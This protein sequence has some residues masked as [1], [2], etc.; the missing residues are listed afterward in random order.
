MN[1][2]LFILKLFFFVLLKRPT[3]VIR[4]S[5]GK[6]SL[7]SGHVSAHFIRDCQDV[8]QMEKIQSGIIFGVAGA[9]A[10]PV[11]KASKEVSP[12]GLQKIRNVWSFYS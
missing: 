2:S 3:F 10:K 9:A 7:Q 6:A 1:Q 8:I 5:E 11:I 4:I 12:I